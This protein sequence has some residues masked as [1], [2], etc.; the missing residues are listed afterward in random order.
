MGIQVAESLLSACQTDPSL[1][2]RRLNDRIHDLADTPSVFKVR[3]NRRVVYDS[4]KEVAKKD[5]RRLQVARTEPS[6]RPQLSAIRMLWA[7]ENCPN[8]FGPRIVVGRVVLEFV[9]SL[10][11]EREGTAVSINLPCKM[12]FPS[13]SEPGGVD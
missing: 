8:T 4:R 1:F 10:P 7:G 9:G 13:W 12:V 11:I 5:E 2:V 6:K 3:G